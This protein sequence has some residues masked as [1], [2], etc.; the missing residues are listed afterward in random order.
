MGRTSG[1]GT[2]TIIAMCMAV[3]LCTA[4][5]TAQR[6]M[7]FSLWKQPLAIGKENEEHGVRDSTVREPEKGIA[8]GGNTA[9]MPILDVAAPYPTPFGPASPSGSESVVLRLNLLQETFVSMRL[10]TILSEPVQFV[11]E[12]TYSAGSHQYVFTPGRRLASGQ[13]LLCVSTSQS[14]HWLR[15]LYLR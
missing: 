15:L 7:P 10:F 4:E 12:S 14:V 13:Y 6:M 2:G 5:T 9:A 3:F 8:E 11:H 1:A